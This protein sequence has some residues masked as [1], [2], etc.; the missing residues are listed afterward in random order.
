MTRS[1]GE[2]STRHYGSNRGPRP[3]ATALRWHELLPTTQHATGELIRWLCSA[4]QASQFKDEFISDP[5]RKEMNEQLATSVLVAGDRGF[6]KTTVLLSAATAFHQPPQFFEESL[7]KGNAEAAELCQQ[8]ESNRKRV[9]WLDLLDMEPLP[10][11]A[12][13]LATLLVRVRDVLGSEGGRESGRSVSSLLSEEG[14]EDPWSKIDPLVRQATFMWENIPVE[15]QDPRQRA[16]Y[17]LRAAEIYA[18]FRRNF[19]EAL[20]AVSNHLAM[21]SGLGKDEGTILILPIDN[22]DRS[23]QHL[24]LILKLTRMV[25][26]RRLWFLLS[27]GQQEFQLFLERTFQRELSQAGVD[28]HGTMA[29]DETR[30]I[31]RRQAAAAMRRVLP[32]AHRIDIRSLHPMEAWTFKA[33]R[34]LTHEP[35]EGAPL[36]EEL[37]NLPLPNAGERA[38]GLKCFADLFEVSERLESEAE[39]EQSLLLKAYRDSVRDE[40]NNGAPGQRRPRNPPP[41]GR[42]CASGSSAKG[43]R[44]SCGSTISRRCSI[45]RRG[46]S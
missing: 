37:R 42:S 9:V 39:G 5:S 36:F 41:R 17:Q 23:I 16:E 38:H 30:A 3:E 45:S 44:A 28:P 19:F 2:T 21:R 43:A 26:S 40:E 46:A 6:G 31:G 20:N 13:L 12:N 22:V 1:T 27:S 14:T 8:I 34:S 18:G 25:A 11:E 4:V 32:L 15:G 29:E 33:P 10:T 35:K 24:H 7:V